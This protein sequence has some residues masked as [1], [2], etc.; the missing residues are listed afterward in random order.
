MLNFSIDPWLPSAFSGD[1]RGNDEWQITGKDDTAFANGYE[2]TIDNSVVGDV[3]PQVDDQTRFLGDVKSKILMDNSVWRGLG[4]IKPND[5]NSGYINIPINQTLPQNGWYITTADRLPI[6]YNSDNFVIESNT[7]P[8]DSFDASKTQYPTDNTIYVNPESDKQGRRKNILM[9]IPV[10]NNT[11][12]LVE[13]EASTPIFVDINNAEDIN[14]KNLNFRI[15]NKDF[16]PIIQAE[17]TAIM[18]ILI[19]KPTE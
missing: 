2:D 4:F 12:G 3:I 1:E 7:L 6:V 11:T 5:G 18:S 16:S 9:T 14:V 10:N 15:L 19:K 17:E 13:Y 8:L